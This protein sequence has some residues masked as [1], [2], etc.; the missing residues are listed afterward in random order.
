MG[1]RIN[2]AVS[3]SSVPQTWRWPALIIATLFVNIWFCYVPAEIYWMQTPLGAVGASVLIPLL[4]F[5]GPALASRQTGLGLFA[6]IDHAIG[7]IPGH[8]VRLCAV[9]FLVFWIAQV[10]SIPADVQAMSILR[11]PASTLESL[12]IALTMLVFLFLTG[13]QSLATTARLYFSLLRPRGR[14]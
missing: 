9:I 12:T 1:T 3:K 13:L 4:F 5:V 11:R 10:I 2:G 6:A 14:L 8:G 7:T